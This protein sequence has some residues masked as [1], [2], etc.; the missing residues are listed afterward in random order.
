MLAGPL[1]TDE[2]PHRKPFNFKV[3]Y[4]GANTGTAA[5]PAFAHMLF[6][7]ND[8]LTAE[9]PG[10]APAAPEVGA[11]SSNSSAR[12]EGCDLYEWSGGQLHLVNVLPGNTVASP[13]GVIGAGRRLEE[14]T[15]LESPNF[16]HAISDDGSRIFW[17]EEES[18]QVYVR[19]DGDKTLEVPGPG[20]CKESVTRAER[21]CFLTASADGS[22]VLLSDGQIYE[23]NEAE[24]AYE[25]ATDL[26]DGQTG[27]QGIAG[28]SEDLSRVYFV[29]TA[30]LTGDAKQA[31][32]TSISGMKE[33]PDSSPLFSAVTTG[34]ETTKSMGTGRHRCRTAPPRSAPTVAT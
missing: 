9:V 8:A 24:S 25:P 17:S 5:V 15:L 12:C 19:I 23:L 28:A 3:I 6:E 21:A 30:A 29:D 20:L 16:D 26:A 27:F 13:G 18:G 33:A 7:A 11:G 1:I 14:E 2:P 32:T 34:L 4:A 31:S 22:Q 10:T